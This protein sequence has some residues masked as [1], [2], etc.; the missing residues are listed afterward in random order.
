MPRFWYDLPEAPTV[1]V[2]TSSREKLRDP[3][4]HRRR[5]TVRAVAR[6]LLVAVLVFVGLGA[7]AGS[8]FLLGRLSATESAAGLLRPSSSTTRPGGNNPLAPA[9]AGRFGLLDEI[10][11]IVDSEFYDPAAVD[12]QKMSYGAAKGL[13]ETLGEPNTVFADQATTRLSEQNIQGSF[14]GVGITL[15]TTEGALGVAEVV[16]GGPAATAGIQA[17][18]T[19]VAVDG[20][21][22]AGMSSP[23]AVSLI[24][25][26]EGTKV[27]L[28]IGRE[29]W[30][31]PREFPLTRAVIKPVNT[32]TRMMDGSVGYIR[33]ISFTTGSAQEVEAGLRTLKSQGA[34][35]VVLDLRGNSGGLLQSA[36][37]ISSQFISDGIVM[38][39]QR[40]TP[41]PRQFAARPGGQ[42]TDLPVAVLV[43]RGSASASEIVAGA[44]QDRQRGVLVGERTY[45]KDTVQN[46]HRLSDGSSVRVT[47]A[48]WYTPNRQ[49]IAQKGL[50][51]DL[52]VQITDDDLKARRDP[53]LDAALDSVRSRMSVR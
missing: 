1:S 37:E 48:K 36:V 26:Q 33:V 30:A 23:T 22:T 17:G 13:V 39:E 34:K 8:S 2:P 31:Q 50:T 6:F 29:G 16:E 3:D 7:V 24:R 51:P 15:S 44:L 25:G 20:K 53:Q 41:E 35:A 21:P 47:I 28:T 42:A 18:D 43:N 52:A 5:V 9:P 4:T 14:G 49:E 40:R 27:V 45:G 32:T 38:M 46:V 10:A 19:I 11:G 12:D